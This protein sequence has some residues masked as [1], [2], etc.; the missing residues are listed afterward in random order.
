MPFADMINYRHPPSAA[1]YYDQEKGGLVVKALADIKKGEEVC[2]GH[3][4][5]L[6]SQN[7]FLNYGFLYENSTVGDRAPVILQLDPADPL[8][9]KKRKALPED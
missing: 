3:S 7:L 5:P 9:D 2:F 1:W 8:L 4:E 6:C